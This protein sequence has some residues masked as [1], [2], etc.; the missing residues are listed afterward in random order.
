MRDYVMDMNKSF[1]GS[2]MKR[3]SLAVMIK[4]PQK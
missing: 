4:A 3:K 2:G 1:E